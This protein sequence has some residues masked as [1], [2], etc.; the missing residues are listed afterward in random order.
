MVECADVALVGDGAGLRS[1]ARELRR[2][3]R[4]PVVVE[5]FAAVRPCCG[6]WEVQA[7]G[8]IW[9]VRSVVV[10]TAGED[11]RLL[12]RAICD[13]LDRRRPGLG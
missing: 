12:L 7:G 10:S 11:P 4:A 3:G 5:S 1:V 8:T 13:D 2:I 6:S 9:F